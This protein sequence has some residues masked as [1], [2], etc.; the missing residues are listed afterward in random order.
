MSAQ[1]LARWR[2]VLGKVAEPHGIDCGGDADAE[3]VEQLVGFL[4]E[5]GDGGGPSKDRTGGRGES[6]L[7]VPTWVDAVN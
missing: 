4:F 5:S 7:T 6:Q 1:S 3:R 2:L